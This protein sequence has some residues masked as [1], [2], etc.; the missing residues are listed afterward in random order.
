MID[1][2]TDIHRDKHNAPNFDVLF[3]SALAN[4][5]NMVLILLDGGIR[6]SEVYDDGD[7]NARAAWGHTDSIVLQ[8]DAQ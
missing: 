1:R 3:K 6:P 7:L 8:E 5:I 4:T 2:L